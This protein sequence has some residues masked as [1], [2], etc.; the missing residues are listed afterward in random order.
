MDTLLGLAVLSALIGGVIGQWM[1]RG[2]LNGM[3]LGFFGGPLEWL[4]IGWLASQK[5]C[6]AC[7]KVVDVKATACTHCTRDIP[8]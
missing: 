7:R 3:A 2:V 8:A 6:P 5:L 4:L 1:R